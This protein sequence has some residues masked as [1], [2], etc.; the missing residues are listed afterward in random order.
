MPETSPQAPPLVLVKKIEDAKI[1]GSKVASSFVV[2]GKPGDDGEF[3]F[4][5]IVKVPSLELSKTGGAPLT[6]TLKP[7]VQVISAEVKGLGNTPLPNQMVQI[8]DPDSR[9]PVGPPVKTDDKGRVV[10]EVPENK[11]YDIH[12]VDDDDLDH[13]T[14]EADHDD[15]RATLLV[16]LVDRAGAPVANERAQLKDPAGAATEAT[17]GADGRIELHEVQA[18][19]FEI[20]VKGKTVKAHTLFTEDLE[21][22]QAAPY[23]VVVA[24]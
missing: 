4:V 8:V 23:R 24:V 18:G 10:A 15:L 1:D 22:P 5:I 2:D 17:T 12:I 19:A 6:A 13:T 3:E 20:G 11:A 16:E 21:G 7:D 9:E 14:P